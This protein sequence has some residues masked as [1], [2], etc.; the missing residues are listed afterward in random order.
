MHPDGYTFAFDQLEQLL[1]RKHFPERTDRESG[2]IL[3]FLRA[4]GQEY[5]RWTFS[6]RVGRGVPADP[7][8]HPGVQANA[9]FSGRKRMDI[10]AW[11]GSHPTIIEVKERVT[12]ATL[13][14]ILTY[15]SL[16]PEEFPDAPDPSLVVI[17][18]YSDPDTV[19]V[20]NAHGITVYLFAPTDA[21][22]DAARGRV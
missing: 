15:R 5:D 12:P 22:G 10:L 3:D 16:F 21:A 2:V 7:T 9:A 20:L 8:H 4:H 11:S 6:K 14:Q 1:V 19:A 18:R 17:G 13:G